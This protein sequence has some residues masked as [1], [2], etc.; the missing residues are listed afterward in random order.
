MGKIAINCV[1]RIILCFV[2]L[3]QTIFGFSKGNYFFPEIGLKDVKLKELN[4]KSTL[5]IVKSLKDYRR[6]FGPTDISDTVNHFYTSDIDN[7]NTSELLYFGIIN[8]EGYWTIIWKADRQSYRLLGELYGKINGIG[9]SFSIST[10]APACR[11]SDCGFANLY[12]IKDDWT[13]FVQSVAIFR[14]VSLPDSPPIREKITLSKANWYLR[15]QPVISD[16]PDS[17]NIE[18]YGVLRGNALALLDKGA[19]ASATASFKGIAGKEWLFCVLD[20]SSNADYN[21]YKGYKTKN[22][23]IC[24]WITTQTIDCRENH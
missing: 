15:A 1:P 10:L 3:L 19:I 20:G 13:D 24:G 9:D 23:R 8:A 22:R 12:R 11:G 17:M 5:K 14:G 18:R 2:F 6:I 4:K 7:D 16:K 21:V